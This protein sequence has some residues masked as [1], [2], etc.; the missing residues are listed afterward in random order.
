MLE[1]GDVVRVR[2]LDGTFVNHLL[3]SLGIPLGLGE[4]SAT[5]QVLRWT[6]GQ[7]PLLPPATYD[8]ADAVVDSV[9]G[10]YDAARRRWA[11]YEVSGV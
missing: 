3:T 1:P 9:G 2:M 11:T 5:T 7:P 6:A 10:T 8:S 4:W